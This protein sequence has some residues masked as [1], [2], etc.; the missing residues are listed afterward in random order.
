MVAWAIPVAIA[1]GTTLAGYFGAESQAEAQSEANR[2]NRE[3]EILKLQEGRRQFDLSSGIQQHQFGY[4]AQR[5]IE[6]EAAQQHQFGYG[7]KRQIEEIQRKEAQYGYEALS[8][9]EKSISRRQ[10]EDQINIAQQQRFDVMRQENIGRLDPYSKTG[11]AASSERSALLGLGGVEAQQAAMGRFTESAG[12][13]YLR[14]SQE[15]ALLRSGSKIG[16]LGGG[17]IQTALQQ[18]AFDIAQTDYGRH[19]A[20]LGGV[21]TEGLQ[22]GQSAISAGY[23]PG[24]IQTGQ[25]VGVSDTPYTPSAPGTEYSPYTDFTSYNAYAPPVKSSTPV[26][27]T[28][29]PQQSNW[30]EEYWLQQPTDPSRDYFQEQQPDPSVDYFG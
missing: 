28:P 19:L 29:T 23:G 21:S 17:N 18:Q 1:A 26:P 20:R 25:D 13:K 4:G 27:T 11:Q 5:G 15:R 3:A 6:Q 2:V 7:A 24:Y 14:E 10:R 22:A 8:A 30:G 9:N 12:Q 16:S